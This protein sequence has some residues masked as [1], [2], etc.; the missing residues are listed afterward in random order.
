LQGIRARLG[1][2][3]DAALRRLWPLQLDRPLRTL[4]W[5]WARP[6]VRLALRIGQF[7]ASLLFV[8]L[9]VRAELWRVVSFYKLAKLFAKVR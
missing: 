7:T 3:L 6:N 1:W 4:R 5:L 2:V 9:Y 8:V